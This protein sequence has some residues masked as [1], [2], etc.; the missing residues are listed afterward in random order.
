[1]EYLLKAVKNKSK[2]KFSKLKCHQKT[3]VSKK[4]TCLDSNTLLLL[5]KYME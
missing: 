1:M 4:G 5:K 2:K 3:K